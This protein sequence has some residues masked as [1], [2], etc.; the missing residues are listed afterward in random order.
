MM[1][2]LPHSYMSEF[3]LKHNKADAQIDDHHYDFWSGHILWLTDGMKQVPYTF[4]L[5]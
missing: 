2:A 4:S 5:W 1:D 3:S